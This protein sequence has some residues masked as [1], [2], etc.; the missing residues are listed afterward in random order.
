MNNQI[1][2][3][4]GYMG[5]GSS[6]MTDL[7]TEIE[8]YKNTT[9]SFEYIFM[10]CPGGLFD[11]EDKLLWGNNALRSDEAVHVFFETMQD[12]YCKPNYWPSGYKDFLS[13]DFLKYCKEFI[14][15]IACVSIDETFWYYQENPQN[16]KMHVMSILYGK[17]ILRALGVKKPLRYNEMIFAY[18]TAEEFYR[19]AKK[20]LGKIFVAMGSG[21][22]NIIVDQLLLP[23]NIYRIDR[24][25]GDELRVFVVERDPRD[26]FLMNKYYW[27]QKNAQ[28]PYP[29]DVN[30][31][32]KMYRAIRDNE[33]SLQDER[34][35]RLKFEEL[36]YDY[37]NALARIYNHLGIAEEKHLRKLSIFDPKISVNNTQIFKRNEKYFEES[38]IIATL[39]PEYIYDFSEKNFNPVSDV[40]LF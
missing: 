22:E 28:V 33:I 29:Y 40:D 11:L 21:N 24:Y 12:L 32:C 26:V 38:E 20:F 16:F 35:L 19:A 25:F 30:D 8:G 4:S 7:L 23:H 31:F 5:S 36:V 18:P 3:T 39:L 6:A 13:S 1:V 17:K 14:S 9:N 15:D 10:H 34:I 2:V 27:S 37:D